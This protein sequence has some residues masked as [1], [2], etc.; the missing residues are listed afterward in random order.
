MRVESPLKGWPPTRPLR[1]QAGFLVEAR[2]LTPQRA[3]FTDAIGGLIN[4]G[5]VVLFFWMLSAEAFV[6]G[7]EIFTA[8]AVIIGLC[9]VVW[10][11]RRGWGRSFFGKTTIIEFTPDR[12]RIKGGM[13][14]LNYDRT[15]PHEF[16]FEIHDKAEEEEHE[17]IATKRKAAMEGKKELPKVEKFF[18]QSF[19]VILRYAG[20]RV[21]VAS[22]FGKRDAEALLVRLQLLD[23]MMDAARGD[24]TTPVYAE[25]D[26]QYGERPE[27][28]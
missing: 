15:L 16:N 9:I 25:A 18:R 19:H 11:S 13:R 10:R 23:Q 6:S 27:A 20:Q 8:I 4:L 2:H 3:K 21:D 12:I 1:R 26:K 28:G 17:E 5:G 24:S 7:E 14:F 22:V